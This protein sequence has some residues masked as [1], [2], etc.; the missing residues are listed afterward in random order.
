MILIRSCDPIIP[1]QYGSVLL[2]SIL[3]LYAAEEL[4]GGGAG[5]TW[6]SF[7]DMVSSD[8][9]AMASSP[10]TCD[11]SILISALVFSPCL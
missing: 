6:S 7:S 11:D 10:V 9:V 3:Q 8:P 5:I 1:R 4:G 2:R